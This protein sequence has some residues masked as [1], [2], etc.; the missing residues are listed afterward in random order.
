[1]CNYS[2]GYKLKLPRQ[3]NTACLKQ[4]MPVFG[5][6]PEPQS[7]SNIVI[8]RMSGLEEGLNTDLDFAF[9]LSVMGISLDACQV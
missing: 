5:E 3:R 4:E 9:P 6:K 8:L 1:M 7:V 2:D